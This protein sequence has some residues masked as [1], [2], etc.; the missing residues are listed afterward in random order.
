MAGL[1]QALANAPDI[2]KV[3]LKAFDFLERSVRHIVLVQTGTRTGDRLDCRLLPPAG[4]V[5]FCRV[6]RCLVH[7][8]AV[9]RLQEARTER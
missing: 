9:V 8:F 3:S 4:L 1:L 5:R 2:P 6:F 7:C